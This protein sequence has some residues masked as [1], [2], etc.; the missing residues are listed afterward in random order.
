MSNQNT[1]W[2]GR[3][4]ATRQR[5]ERAINVGNAGSALL[6]T[7]INRTV[8]QLTLRE[9]GLQAVLPRRASQP[10]LLWRR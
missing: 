3:G 2:L 7:F 8:Q 1:S 5:F 6:Q 10:Q 9:F 4:D